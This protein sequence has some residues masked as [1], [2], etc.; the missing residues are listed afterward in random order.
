MYFDDISG[1]IKAVKEGTLRG[2]AV[3]RRSAV[4]PRP[5]SL[6]WPNPC[7]GSTSPPEP[8]STVPPGCPQ[9]AGRSFHGS[10]A[11]TFAHESHSCVKSYPGEPRCGA[12]PQAIDFYGF[13]FEQ[14]RSTGPRAQHWR[15]S[16]GDRQGFFT[17]LSTDIVNEQKI[18]RGGL[19][20]V[21]E[22]QVNCDVSF[23]AQAGLR[24][25]GGFGIAR[26]ETTR[27]VETIAANHLPPPQ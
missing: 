11:I 17:D 15:G 25:A 10:G 5:T 27:K 13:I 21:R 24:R 26:F 7:P 19:R 4:P 3:T 14:K 22:A 9:R 8:P 6:R 12:S 23:A 18:R 2:L 20:L 16:W 1:S